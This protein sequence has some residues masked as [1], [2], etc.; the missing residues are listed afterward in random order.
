MAEW[1]SPWRPDPIP[2]LLR[3][4]PPWV[5]Y[6][7]LIDLLGYP[8]RDERVREARQAMVTHPRLRSLIAR[9]GEWP[10]Q[11]L[12]RHN[13][14]RHPLHLLTVLADFGLRADDPGMAAL[15]RKVMGHQSP[16]GAFQT[17]VRLPRAFGGSG[18]AA[19]TWV[20]CD[21]PSLLY[22]LAAYGRYEDDAVQQAAR[23]LAGLVR[24]N[25]WPCSAG[26]ELGRFRGPGR[27]E[28]P[29]PLATLLALKALAWFPG[30]AGEAALQPG[31][32]LLLAQWE[33]ATGRRHYLFG[34][35]SGFR[36]L[37]YPFV[38]YDILHTA[39]V[40]TRIPAARR[41]P[42][43]GDMVQAILDRRDRDNRFTPGSVWMAWADW[44]FGQKRQP[45]PWMTFLVL[46]L[47]RRLE[48][49][50]QGRVLKG[51]RD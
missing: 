49:P 45:S 6:R 31:V 29:C 47:L 51:R 46:R 40:L 1:T 18:Q 12:E 36:R 50:T 44:D 19:W 11:A 37:K 27:K 9:A 5:R 38:W 39:E 3:E 2:W 28:D 4:G 24:A 8:E 25:G 48:A 34:V 32:E 26:S 17:L 13:D 21:A 33:H 23:S 20:L 14:A 42:R 30:Q 16:Q 15:V 22:A 7:T 35:G 43:L 41:D 10:A